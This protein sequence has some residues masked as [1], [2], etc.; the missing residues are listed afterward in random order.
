MVNFAHDLL[1]NVSDLQS[2]FTKFF[3]Q[4]VAMYYLVAGSPVSVECAVD[5][6]SIVYIVQ[7]KP[8][9]VEELKQIANTLSTTV[10][11]YGRIYTPYL[12][13]KGDKLFVTLK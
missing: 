11:A 8:D 10:T 2:V 5:G 6:S 12:E 9:R 7:V 3:D 13:I 1:A 4:H